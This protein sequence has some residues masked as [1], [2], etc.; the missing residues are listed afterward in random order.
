M[1]QTISVKFIVPKGVVL[2]DEDENGVA[3]GDESPWSWVIENATLYYWDDKGKCHE[4][5][6]K[7]EIIKLYTNCELC[8]FKFSLLQK[9][10]KRCGRG[11]DECVAPREL[12]HSWISGVVCKKCDTTL[13]PHTEEEHLD[14]THSVHKCPHHNR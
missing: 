4:V 9:D 12:K 1:R 2:L 6:G 7:Y 5:Q 10:R 11:R 3:A 13:P 8:G 14:P